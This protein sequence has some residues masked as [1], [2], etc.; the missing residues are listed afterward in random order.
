MGP[1]KKNLIF[2]IML[3][4]TACVA[5]IRPV[6]TQD[7]KSPTTYNVTAIPTIFAKSMEAVP[8][9]K[10]NW[11][12]ADSQ[13]LKIDITITGLDANAKIEDF[14]CDPYIVT[15]ELVELS[16]PGREDVRYLADQPGSPREITY[17][18]GLNSPILSETLDITMNV[19]LGPC[20]DY[21]NFQETNVTPTVIP[22][23]IG[24]YNFNFQLPVRKTH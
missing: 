7:P 8:T 10:L 24:N 5:A 2:L 9:V 21:L 6:E 20:A 3:L 19:T 23:L 22:N 13:I 14:V 4:T 1:L 12:Y 15:K 18:Y 16:R 17:V 11:A